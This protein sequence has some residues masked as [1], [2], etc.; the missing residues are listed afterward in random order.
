[1]KANTTFLVGR[2]GTGKSTVFQRVQADLR[3]KDG[4]AS[5][6]VDIKTV[7][8]SSAT[9][10]AVAAKLADITSA[11]PRPYLERLLLYRAFLEAVIEEVKNQIDKR[12]QESL[13]ARVKNTFSGTLEE[14]SDELD[15]LLDESREQRFTSVLGIKQI[16]V[17]TSTEE[18]ESTSASAKFGATASA[19]PSASG[20]FDHSATSQSKSGDTAKYSDILLKVV[21]IK[22]LIIKLRNI[23]Q[24]VGV[25]HLY[26]F[27]DDFSELPEDAMK[28]VVD[29]LLAP[30][31]NWSEELI[32]FKI[33]AYPGRIYYGDID[34][35]KADLVYLDLYDLYGTTGKSDMEDKAID[36][37]RRLVESRLHH[38]AGAPLAHFA[39]PHD[40]DLWEL[41][42]YATS[43]NPRNIGHILYY[44][45]QSH[46]IY[47][48][49]IGRQAIRAAAR[50]YYEEKIEHYFRV[51]KFLHESFD[52]RSSI[53]SLKRTGLS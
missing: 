28:V 43:G 13:W 29:T 24:K 42:F 31:N 21:D 38:F 5:A 40:A 50:R 15:D 52:E 34:V 33:A 48:R 9:D 36:F 45:H 4:Y 18:A 30:L 39:E 6:Y 26:V 14:L 53:Y 22:A 49:R 7:Y 46:L 20:G 47:G 3:N 2:K 35:T 32:K 11:L 1:M 19:I 44:L 41:L 25:R 8:E 10:P 16:E 51:N 17:A 37:T 27:V 12:L 23:L